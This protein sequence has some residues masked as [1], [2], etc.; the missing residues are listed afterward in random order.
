[1][2]R[3]TDAQNR[4]FPQAN[5]MKDPE[6]SGIAT[7]RV[8]TGAAKG[9]Q[10]TRTQ[11]ESAQREAGQ[12]DHSTQNTSGRSVIV[13]ADTGGEM[14]AAYPAGF[15]VS[16]FLRRRLQ[17]GESERLR[18]RIIPTTWQLMN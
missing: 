9:R 17:G 1:M 18:A 14:V 8:V 4:D 10:H 15:W 7:T 2:R 12:Q 3:A 16:K 13:P 6:I 11:A 5:K